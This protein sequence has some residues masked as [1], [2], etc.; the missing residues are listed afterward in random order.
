MSAAPGVSAS[1]ACERGAFSMSCAMMRPWGPEP[2]VRDK[3]MPNSAARR[4]ASGVIAVPPGSR[5]GPKL[6]GG[7]RTSKNGSSLTGPVCCGACK[8]E[9]DAVAGGGVSAGFLAGGTGEIAGCLGCADASSATTATAPAATRISDSTPVVVD[10]TSIDTLSV[11][12]SNRL[13]PGFTDSPAVLN[14]LVILPSATVS[15]SCGISTSMSAFP[16]AASFD[17]F[18]YHLGIGAGGTQDQPIA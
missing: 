11:S 17:P 5:A 9:A 10:G 16:D 6:R 18:P 4:R 15:P 3:S 14:H 7:V 12:I 1:A 2:L 13:S 8:I